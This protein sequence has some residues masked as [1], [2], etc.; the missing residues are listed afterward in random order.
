MDNLYSFDT[1]GV[2]ECYKLESGKVALVDMLK[3]NDYLN[4]RANVYR[5]QKIIEKLGFATNKYNA[6]C[7]YHQFSLGY[8]PIFHTYDGKI[9]VERMCKI[10]DEATK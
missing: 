8:V 5:G 6:Y 4:K 10:V 1:P 7:M 2:W 3:H 9:D